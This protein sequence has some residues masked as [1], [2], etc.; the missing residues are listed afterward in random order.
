M[1]V[2]G[3]DMMHRRRSF[4]HRMRSGYCRHV[5]GVDVTPSVP[6]RVKLLLDPPKIFQTIDSVVTEAVMPTILVL[7]TGNSCRSHMAEG[8]LRAEL[9]AAFDIKSAGSA[10]T[11]YVH[12]LAIRAMG[13]IGIDLEGH[14]SKHV[15]KFLDDD[16]ETVITVCGKADQVCPV[17]SG[18]V[19]YHHFSFD[20]PADAV[21]T[22]E[23]QME[24]FRCVR[25]QIKTVFSAY[26]AG[27]LDALRAFAE[28][29][30]SNG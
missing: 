6:R 16:I 21:G 13:E 4:Q 5:G 18:P 29:S 28:E 27:R 19:N 23:E 11:G 24:T 22:E 15:N 30:D 7:C 8:I 10:P 20:D 25:D 1:A 26:A 14:R 3:T 2:D 12:P 9:G 17:F